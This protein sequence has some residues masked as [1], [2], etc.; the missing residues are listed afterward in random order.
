M[1][2]P[3]IDVVIGSP[4]CGKTTYLM[5]QIEKLLE[6][7]VPTTQIGFLTFSVVAIE[8]ATARTLERFNIKKDNIPYF[9]T[10]HSMAY[11]L[12]GMDRSQ[13]FDYR[14]FIKFASLNGYHLSYGKDFSTE[15]FAS[16]DD[17]ILQY[18]QIARLKDI[19]LKEFKRTEVKEEYISYR[20]LSEMA[21]RYSQYKLGNCVLDYTDMIAHANAEELFIPKL[22][23]LFIDEAQDL[24]KIQWKFIEKIASN[25]DK[26]IVAGD[27]KQSINLFAGADVDYFVNL[28]GNLINLE[29]SYRI[30]RSVHTIALRIMKL[31]KNKHEV[32]WKPRDAE[33]SVHRVSCVPYGKFHKDD[34]LVLTRTKSQL[35]EIVDRC[36]QS[37]FV[38]TVLKKPPIDN[39]VFTAIKVFKAREL[40]DVD[41]DYKDMLQ[42]FI[43]KK[44]YDSLM[45][46]KTW[47]TAFTRLTISQRKYVSD[48]LA[49]MEKGEN[50]NFSKAKIRLSTIHGSKGTEAT[51]VVVVNKTSQLIADDMLNC[52]E[53]EETEHKVLFVAVTRAKENL[54]IVEDPDAKNIYEIL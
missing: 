10:I 21:E 14:H 53:A 34:W 7:G 22:K 46:S 30:P 49:R 12:L 31:I 2:H 13:V 40:T 28:K 24:S 18:V 50:I 54:Y 45:K 15:S 27:S 33:G 9:R 17:K 47:F 37:G 48:L 39:D 6:Q 43:P 3:N 5:N 38:F 42:K 32:V 52:S 51:N 29:Q 1:K 23:Y 20:E 11:H 16:K 25:A 41:A 8:E 19:P 4:G 44:Y 35:A 26:V 36:M